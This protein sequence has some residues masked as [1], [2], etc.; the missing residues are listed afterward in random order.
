[1]ALSTPSWEVPTIS[2]TRYVW[3]DMRVLLSAVAG[4]P[5]VIP[6]CLTARRCA[7]CRGAAGDLT[8]VVGL[9]GGPPGRVSAGHAQ[10]Q[11]ETALPVRPPMGQVEP[12]GGEFATY[13]LLVE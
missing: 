2:V 7:R 6:R 1:M 3:S 13:P 10:G 9:E 5:R 8:R 11:G 12:G 4:V